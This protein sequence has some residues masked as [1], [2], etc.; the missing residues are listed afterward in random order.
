MQHCGNLLLV[1]SMY[2][3]SR[4]EES[5]DPVLQ[6]KTLLGPKPSHPWAALI[7]QVIL[8]CFRRFCV[9][10]LI[11]EYD[12]PLVDQLWDDHMDL[13]RQ[14]APAGLEAASSFWLSPEN[15][16]HM[17]STLH[18]YNRFFIDFIIIIDDVMRQENVEMEHII[19]KFFDEDIQHIIEQW[20]EDEYRPFLI[21]PM[22]DVK[23]DEFTDEQYDIL[24]AALM[25]YSEQNTHVIEE[26][27]VEPMPEPMP[28]PV[29]E[30]MPEPVREPMPEPVPEPMPEPVPEP[31][32]EP[33]PEPVAE[34]VL[35]P[36][37]Q[38]CTPPTPITTFA[39]AI[40]RRKTLRFRKS[41]ITCGKTRK[42]IPQDKQRGD[43]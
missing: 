27:A 5:F 41:R 15:I 4:M 20:L 32:P 42:L 30:P 29:P 10:N 28:E 25:H 36:P 16:E 7:P 9:K 39:Q 17:H 19:T 23:D 11:E 34:I 38:H 18:D 33:M 40:S 35:P 13:I 22:D 31:M 43:D 21:F 1:V 37:P 26:P 12:E 6:L 14:H 24:I 8:W 3:D 2:H